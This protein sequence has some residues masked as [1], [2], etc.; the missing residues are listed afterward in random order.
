MEKGKGKRG[1][2]RGGRSERGE[3][4][5]VRKRTPEIGKERE[6]RGRFF[7]FFPLLFLVL[8]SALE[9]NA[10]EELGKY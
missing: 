10:R 9:R 1:K 6:E 2:E 3:V 5:G 8:S 4:R 7:F